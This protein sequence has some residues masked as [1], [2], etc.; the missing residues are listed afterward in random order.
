L[1]GSSPAGIFGAV[2][3]LPV[4]I[5]LLAVLLLATPAR[6]EEP[7]P[8]GVPDLIGARGLSLGAYRGL[9]PGNDGM[10]TNA[11][12]LAARRR[13]SIETQWLLDRAGADN[14]F[15]SLTASVVDS[16]GGA[17]AGFGYTRVL[18]GPWKGNLFHVPVAMPLGDRF[19]LGATGKWQ[20]LDGPNQDQ[21]RAA[22]LDASAFWQAS[23]VFS[24]GGAVYNLLDSGHSSQ[25]PRAYGA[26][27]AVG[28]DR[29]FHL[30]FD[31]RG[32]TRGPGNLTSLYALGG[33]VLLA[34]VA[35]LRASYVKDDTRHASFWSAGAGYISSAGIGVDLAYRQCI[36][37]SDERVLAVG[38]K[39]FVQAQ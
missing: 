26:G 27:A 29:T 3:N 34:D 32:D 4:V 24:L 5:G 21:M 38:L 13:Y 14:A 31:W 37:R 16:E 23:S 2:R 7:L 35:P 8:T 10:F 18:S 36:E 17:T 39:I 20:S 25:Q 30:A 12:A 22:N 11:A 15:Q 19:F 6:G 9:S 33:E 1:P 28:D